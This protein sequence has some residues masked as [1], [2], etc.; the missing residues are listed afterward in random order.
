MLYSILTVTPL[1]AEHTA[2]AWAWTAPIL[3]LVVDAAVVI[4]VKLDDGAG[5]PGR[6]RWPVAHRLAVDDRPA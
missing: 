5:P 3:P 4:V 2:E 1:M 6:A